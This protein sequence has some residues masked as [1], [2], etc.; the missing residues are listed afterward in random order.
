MIQREKVMEE[1]VQARIN[2]HNQRVEAEE[3]FR[4]QDM[5]RQIR[6]RVDEE[7]NLLEREFQDQRQRL[8]E[9]T[10]KE[11]E[12]DHQIVETAKREKLEADDKAYQENM[13]ATRL[14]E[15]I[16]IVRSQL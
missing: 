8:E 5:E 13:R 7:R 14:E 15:D 12:Y 11:R 2:Q 10:L 1:K 16:H 9:Q 3:Q 4:R 6:D